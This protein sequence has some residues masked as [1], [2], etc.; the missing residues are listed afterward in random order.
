[1]PIVPIVNFMRCMAIVHAVV[2]REFSQA[3]IPQFVRLGAH[4]TPNPLYA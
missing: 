4:T 3:T 2:E 1:L